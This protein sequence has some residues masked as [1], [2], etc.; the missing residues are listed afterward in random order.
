MAE[1]PPENIRDILEA[2]VERFPDKE[3]LLLESD[4]RALTYRQFDDEVNR[5]AATLLSLGVSKGDRVTML[6]TNRAEYLIFYFACFKIGV[7]AGP[8]NALLK[9]REIE[10]IIANSEAQ[11]VVTQPDLLP[12]LEEVRENVKSLRNVIVVD[13]S[14]QWSVLGV[15]GSGFRVPGATPNPEPGTRN[16]ELTPND[17]AVIIYTSGTTGKP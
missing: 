15:P 12:H 17:E 13:E 14:G 11:T 8:V 4:E 16:P 5:A 1:R 10:F 3:F 7:W 2:Q 6:L 9:P